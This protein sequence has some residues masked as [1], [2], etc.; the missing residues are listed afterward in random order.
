MRSGVAP[1]ASTACVS[2]TEATSK[3]QP[4]P[5]Q[6][7][8]DFRRRVGLDGIEH[9]A[10]GQR[11]GEVEVV[12]ADDVEVD[13]EAGSVIGALLE[14]FA[15]ACGHCHPLPNPTGG[16]AAEVNLL[17]RARFRTI[18]EPACVAVIAALVRMREIPFRTA[19]KDGQALSVSPALAP[20]A[21]QKSPS[22]VALSRVARGERA[23]PVSPPAAGRGS[24]EVAS[25]P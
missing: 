6:E 17:R 8:E 5:G 9:L 7:L 1:A 13:H 18:A 22:V 21:N 20:V 25:L 2:L 14:E 11:L 10:V 19:G 15:D 12:L 16:V 4:K 24:K 23:M 3:Q